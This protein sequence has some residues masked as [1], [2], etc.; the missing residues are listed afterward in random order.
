MSCSSEVNYQTTYDG[1]E[2]IIIVNRSRRRKRRRTW[3]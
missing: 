1:I 2:I 3:C